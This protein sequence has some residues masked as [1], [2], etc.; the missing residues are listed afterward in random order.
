MRLVMVP[1]MF[2]LWEL[3]W[4]FSPITAGV[5]FIAAALTDWLDGYLARRV[6]SGLA[7]ALHAPLRRLA[8]PAAPPPSARG[9][10]SR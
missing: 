8:T 2:L 4:R 3:E 1:V 7:W 6:R 10:F 5:V 9:P